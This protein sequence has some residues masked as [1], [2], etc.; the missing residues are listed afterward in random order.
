MRKQYFIQRL[1]CW[2]VKNSKGKSIRLD[3]D[4]HK[5]FK[6]WHAL[7]AACAWRILLRIFVRLVRRNFGGYVFLYPLG[8][9]VTVCE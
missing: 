6:I 7:Q 9:S 2:Y 8:N 5:A 3:L 1:A 4:K